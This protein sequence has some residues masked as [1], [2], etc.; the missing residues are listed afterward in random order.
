MQGNELWLINLSKY[1]QRKLVIGHVRG[2]HLL[3]QGLTDCE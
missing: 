2:T 1:D 3:Q